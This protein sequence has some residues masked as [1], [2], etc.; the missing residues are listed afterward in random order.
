MKK[1]ILVVSLILIFFNLN[2]LDITNPSDLIYYDLEL[3]QEKGYYRHIPELRPYSAQLIIEYLEI[4]FKKGSS[5]EKETARGYLE[6]IKK[7]L[8]LDYELQVDTRYGRDQIGDT[9]GTLNFFI[10]GMINDELS[11]WGNVSANAI[12]GYE[13]PGYYMYYETLPVG[14]RDMKNVVQDTGTIAGISLFSGSSSIMSYGSPELY[15]NLG[16]SRASFGP[17]QDDGIVISQ[18]AKEQ[19]HYELTWRGEDFSYT[20]L[21]LQLVGTDYEGKGNFSQKYMVFH[22][23][24]WAPL[25]WLD[26]GFFETV[27]YGNRFEPLY[28]V[29]F[30]YLFYNQGIVGFSD[31]SLMGL[32]YR[33]LIPGRVEFNGVLYV[34]DIGFNEIIKFN[35]DTKMKIALETGVSWTPDEPWLTKMSLDYTAVFPYMY[36]H[37]PWGWGGIDPP[38]SSEKAT[39]N[40][41][42]Y[43]H[44]GQNL[45][46]TLSPNSDRLS[47]T[48]NWRLDETTQVNFT[49]NYMRHGNA[50]E[51]FDSTD[52]DFNEVPLDSSIFDNGANDLGRNQV[53]FLN[54]LI[55]PTLEHIMQLGLEFNT[56]VDMPF[57]DA[58]RYYGTEFGVGYT[59]EMI[60]NS[61]RGS[62]VGNLIPVPGKNEVNHYAYFMMRVFL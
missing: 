15:M 45:G 61:A 37:Y 19:G 1:T 56:T 41:D 51:V 52:P 5:R 30:S 20:A 57:Q 34:D 6:K 47:L 11:L 40:V 25:D 36:T 60:W 17:F 22:S 28:L 33:I 26:L 49:G 10:R 23:Y 62:T 44:A 3:W 43:T 21:M 29:P 16:L 7:D 13:D 24:N 32:K 55:Q 12:I 39:M 58:K 42:N 53:D 38:Y 27:V 8:T 59:F 14:E 9:Y 31:N 48:S 35:F 2:S 54:F 50:S 4:V 46:V 18:K